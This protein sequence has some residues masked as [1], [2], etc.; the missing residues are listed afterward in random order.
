MLTRHEAQLYFGV[1]EEELEDLVVEHDLMV[2][3][4][5]NGKIAFVHSEGTQEALLARFH[6]MQGFRP[7]DPAV[8]ARA[9]RRR[10]FKAEEEKKRLKGH[11]AKLKKRKLEAK[12]MQEG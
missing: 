3:L 11:T 10:A 1:D 5:P 12:K 9:H 7:D 2:E 4:A 8:M 6:K